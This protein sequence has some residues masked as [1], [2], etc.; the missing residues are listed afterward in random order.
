MDDV[1]LD[2]PVP[3]FVVN[4]VVDDFRR[5]LGCL[6]SSSFTSS[7]TVSFLSFTNLTI[8]SGISPLPFFLSFLTSFD[9]VFGGDGSFLTLSFLTSL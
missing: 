7:P 4:P 5:P 6:L 9:F 3:V 2:V 1:D 8:Q